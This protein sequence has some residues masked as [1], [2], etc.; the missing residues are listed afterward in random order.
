MISSFIFLIEYSTTQ[1]GEEKK[2]KEENNYHINYG[3]INTENENIN[4]FMSSLN[5]SSSSL[6]SMNIND[7]M[8]ISNSYILFLL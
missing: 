3:D 5:P 7:G 4:Q 6:S 1:K 2:E 8:C